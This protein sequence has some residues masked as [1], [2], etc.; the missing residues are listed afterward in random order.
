MKLKE[1]LDKYIDQIKTDWP[2]GINFKSKSKFIGFTIGDKCL[3]IEEL[4]SN[5]WAASFESHDKEF[6]KMLGDL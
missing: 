4:E 2:S 3:S 5:E 1:I 6:N